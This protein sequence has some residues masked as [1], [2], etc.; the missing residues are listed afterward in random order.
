MKRIV[1]MAAVVICAMM[2]TNV[3]AQEKLMAK[4]AAVATK[5]QEK[6]SG[7]GITKMKKE[8]LHKNLELRN[9]VR[10]KFWSIY[11]KFMQEEMKIHENACLRIEKIGIKRVEGKYDFDAMNDEQILAF[12]DNRFQEKK[13]MQDLSFRFYNEIKTIL[14]PKELVKYYTLDKN[15]KKTVAGQ[16]REKHGQPKENK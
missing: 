14:Q 3:Q 6:C 16:A 9:E 13:E 8:Y 11:D 2:L 15:F 12:Y 7:S 4:T 10:E 1:L 5:E